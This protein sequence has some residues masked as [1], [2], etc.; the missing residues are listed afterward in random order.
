MKLLMENWNRYLIEEDIERALQQRTFKTK[1]ELKNFLREEYNKRNIQLTEEELNE[2]LPAALAKIG[3]KIALAAQ[4]AGAG[5]PSQEQF[6][7][8]VGGD[9]DAPA[10]QAQAETETGKVI[11]NGDGTFSATGVAEYGGIR[12]IAQ[13]QA[14]GKAQKLLN[15]AGHYGGVDVV[16]ACHRWLRLCNSYNCRVTKNNLKKY[17]TSFYSAVIISM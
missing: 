8:E 13:N 4:L 17:L 16:D 5:G 9:A 15:D 3:A 2:A 7:T 1:E 14:E 11:D 12:S 10:M 6:D